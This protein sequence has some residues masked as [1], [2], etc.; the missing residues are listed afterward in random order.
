M[1]VMA[2]TK[3]LQYEELDIAPPV[4]ECISAH[5]L[6]KVPASDRHLKSDESINSYATKLLEKKLGDKIELK[7]LRVSKPGLTNR[8]TSKLFRKTPNAKL[9]ATVE[10]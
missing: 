9:Y 3:S 4:P 10:F 7:S 2:K 6:I 1:W 5:Y 8:A